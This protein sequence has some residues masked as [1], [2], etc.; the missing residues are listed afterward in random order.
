[1][2][3]LRIPIE[4]FM[5]G[6]LPPR[7]TIEHP[8]RGRLFPSRVLFEQLLP[9]DNDVSDRIILETAAR[10]HLSM[11]NRQ[12]NS[13]H[14]FDDPSRKPDTLQDKVGSVEVQRVDLIAALDRRVQNTVAMPVFRSELK[15]I[16]NILD[17]VAVVPAQ[18]DPFLTER[19]ARRATEDTA[20]SFTAQT[21]SDGLFPFE[22][23]A[24][25]NA[26]NAANA[27]AAEHTVHDDAQQCAETDDS[28]MTTEELAMQ[29]S[30]SITDDVDDGTD[31]VEISTTQCNDMIHS[32]MYTPEGESA[33]EEAVTQSVV[34]VQL[35]D[36]DDDDEET[37]LDEW[38]ACLNAYDRELSNEDGRVLDTSDYEHKQQ[39][40]T[41][42]QQQQQ[43]QQ[44]QPDKQLEP[45][46]DDVTTTRGDTEQ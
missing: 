1:M 18:V 40:A 9:Q 3:R 20:V 12:L 38:Q 7:V 2:N 33:F 4:R 17:A 35:S 39:A 27:T 42:Q 37:E 30:D 44:Q 8:L 28:S 6:R 26:A 5:A 10:Q 19:V 25:A 21:D 14:V 41:S 23:A 22:R 29:E 34:E 45:L 11:C 36:L 15:G 43:Q 24:A 13:L 16:Q 31:S 46:V 32:A